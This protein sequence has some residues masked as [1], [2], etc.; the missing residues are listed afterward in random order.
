MEA[1]RDLEALEPT[2]RMYDETI[3][4]TLEDMAELE[5]S[6][7]Q[8]GLS[9]HLRSPAF[10]GNG[11]ESTV[12]RLSKE[13]AARYNG[14]A[15]LEEQ[16]TL[17]FSERP[18]IA[19]VL[20]AYEIDYADVN[21][22]IVPNLQSHPGYRF[23]SA[24]DHPKA[25]ADLYFALWNHGFFAWD[26][27]NENN[28]V[29]CDLPGRA[30]ALILADPGTRIY[31]HDTVLSA[32]TRVEVLCDHLSFMEDYFPDHFAA[33]YAEDPALLDALG[34]GPNLNDTNDPL[35]DDEESWQRLTSAISRVAKRQHIDYG[36]WDRIQEPLGF[37]DLPS[38]PPAKPPHGTHTARITA[39]TMFPPPGVRL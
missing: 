39:E 2:A 37:Y 18:P 3:H 35:P 13:L 34:I 4:A 12:V 30:P 26:F 20:Q 32:E 27:F 5:T 28:M 38:I 8:T 1:V 21:R 16:R 11:A 9:R 29:L 14:N 6:R 36:Q 31:L 10:L 7:N 23:T 25:G 22:E 17:L 15:E 19:Q 24:G 33:I